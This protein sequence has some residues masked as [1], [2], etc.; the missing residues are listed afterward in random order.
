MSKAQFFPMSIVNENY[1][2]ID[3]IKRFKFAKKIKKKKQSKK[4]PRR[5]AFLKITKVRKQK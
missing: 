3:K 1:A 2:F 5:Q 4:I